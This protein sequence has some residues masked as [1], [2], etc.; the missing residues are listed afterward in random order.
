VRAAFAVA[1]ISRDGRR[2]AATVSIGVASGS[3]ATAIDLLIT[4]ADEAL[5]RAKRNGR[6]RVEVAGEPAKTP[7]VSQDQAAGTA[8][9]RRRKQEGAV[10]D[11]AP[12]GCIA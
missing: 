8:R 9:G 12:E 7:A 1:S 11:G 10:V 3:P 2:V 5:Y 4:R 6:N